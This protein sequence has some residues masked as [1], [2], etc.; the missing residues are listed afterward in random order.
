MAGIN[1]VTIMGRIGRDP[2]FSSTAS[3]VSRCVLAIATSYKKQD[4]TELT[5]WH[6]VTAWGRQAEVICRYC[7]KGSQLYVEGR[8]RYGQYEKDG[9][10]HYTTDIDILDFQFCGGVSPAQ[11]HDDAP[12][13]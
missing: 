2:E 6:T 1:K 10:K 4:G 5:E 8:L 11:Q 12:P 3:G 13:F 7:Q 9:K